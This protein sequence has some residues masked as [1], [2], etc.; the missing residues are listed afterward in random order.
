MSYESEVISMYVADEFTSPFLERDARAYN[1]DGRIRWLQRVCLWVLGVLGAEYWGRKIEIRT[2]R[3]K[4]DSLSNMI[5]KNAETARRVY[6]KRCRY[7]LVGRKQMAELRQ[8][9]KNVESLITLP[10]V[11]NHIYN[12]TFRGMKVVY[13]PWMDG[14][15]TLPELDKE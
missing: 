14:V 11:N 8:E 5:L 12:R 4:L 1:P 15:L 13:V 7:V 2:L 10:H 9:R 6:G 3:I